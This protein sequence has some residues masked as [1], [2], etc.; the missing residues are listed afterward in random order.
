MPTASES[1][2]E[3]VSG[4][5]ASTENFPVA[6][7]L[8]PRPLRPHVMAF[9]GFA[10]A[11]DDIADDTALSGPDKIVR[12]RRFSTALVDPSWDSPGVEK[13]ALL[14]ASLAARGITPR[15]ALDLV[16]AFVQDA[17]KTRYADWDELIHYCV[18]SAA[19]VGRFLL[20]LHGESRGLWPASDA[21]CNALQVL[22]HLQ[23]VGE[24]YRDLDRVYMPAPWFDEAGASISDLA[25][26]ASTPGVRRVLNRALDGVDGLLAHSAA[27]APA[28]VSTGLA[29]ETAAIQA[30]AERLAVLLRTQDPL[31]MR[32]KPGKAAMALT[33]LRGVANAAGVRLVDWLVG[34]RR[35]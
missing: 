32:V 27:L 10:R 18:R 21:L 8:L 28:L 31:A 4:K 12:L 23:D 20:D 16:D 14:R 17:E 7:L 29:F 6:S 33:A 3:V 2:L 30:L 25:L 13:A 34:R 22:N 11:T 35:A 19:P 9:Y 24:D 26:A 1:S 5:T 15:H